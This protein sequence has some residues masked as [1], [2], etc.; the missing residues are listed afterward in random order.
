M[1]HILVVE[2]WVG[3]SSRLL[4]RA[5]GELGHRFTFL[6]RDLSHYL[7][8]APEGTAHPLLGA[9]NILGA[10][11]NDLGM[12][13]D[14]AERA[15]SA[16]AFD[17]V[18]TGCDYYLETAAH[19]AAHLGLAGP[20][21]DSVARLRRKDL[22][23]Q[24]MAE[25]GLA[26]P[27]FAVV[28]SWDAAAAAADQIGFPLVVKPVDLCAGMLVRLVRDHGELATAWAAVRS[29]QRNA[30]QQERVGVALLEEFLEGPEVSVETV[31]FE[32]RTTVIGLTDKSL[33][34]PPVFVE[35]GHMFPA[36]IDD[37]LAKAAAELTVQTLH[38]F[39]YRHG[40]AHTEVKLTPAG[41]R[42]V[43]VNLRP[44]GNWITELVRRVTG[45]DLVCVLVEMALGV[46]PNLSWR[47]TGVASAAIGFVLPVTPGLVVAVGGAER[48]PSAPEVVQWEF[49]VPT[50]V[51]LTPAQSNNDY[52]GHVM[53]VDTR[54]L[55]ARR[56]VEALLSELEIEVD[57]GDLERAVAGATGE[58]VG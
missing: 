40:V 5:V 15:H 32:G 28:D 31:T 10:E 14:V 43:E 56:R 44:A 1:G 38:A 12:V 2:S 42:L 20:D 27:A 54:G 47:E 52:L 21:P 49:R 13:L 22:L 41:P 19:L 37:E 30:R 35:T 3:A 16:L 33:S 6:T 23:R 4:P 57:A 18:V 8:S 46:E 39:G 11:T 34:P 17:A 48:L 53:A 50:G 9:A 7:R 36:D 26:S 25:A 29:V 51:T 24:G 58:G 55:G 45:V